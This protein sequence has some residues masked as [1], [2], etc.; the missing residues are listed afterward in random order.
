M[1]IPHMNQEYN[2]DLDIYTLT[3]STYKSISYDEP[4]Y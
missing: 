1:E 3:I 4:S 2:L